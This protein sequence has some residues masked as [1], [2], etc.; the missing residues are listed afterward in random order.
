MHHGHL[1]QTQPP[2]IVAPWIAPKLEIRAEVLNHLKNLAEA[3]R[4]EFRGYEKNDSSTIEEARL[5][6][7]RLVNWFENLSI[8]EDELEKFIE[9]L[10]DNTVLKETL[11]MLYGE[12]IKLIEAVRIYKH[13]VNELM[14]SNDPVL[15]DLLLLTQ[16]KNI[17]MVNI[18]STETEFDKKLKRAR[19]RT[20]II[21]GASL[22]PIDNILARYTTPHSPPSPEQSEHWV[23][24]HIPEEAPS[25][26]EIWNHWWSSLWRRLLKFPW[27]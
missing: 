2:A 7:I 17:W 8:T 10:E 15:I 27:I 20:D 12:K 9:T 18:D 25:Q 24:P 13:Q 22:Y 14:F 5:L 21:V 3:I 19:E 1:D 16:K 23:P 4:E 26:L 11:R 6:Q